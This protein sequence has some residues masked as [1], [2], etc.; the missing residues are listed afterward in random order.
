MNARR[1]RENAL[2]DVLGDM[3]DTGEDEMKK[4]DKVEMMKTLFT[5]SRCMITVSVLTSNASIDTRLRRF[6]HNIKNTEERE[7]T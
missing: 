6:V 5:H 2:L 7:Q 3:L 4:N 1:E